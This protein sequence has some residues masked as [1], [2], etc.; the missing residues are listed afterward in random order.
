MILKLGGNVKLKYLKITS[1]M[2]ETGVSVRQVATNETTNEVIQ[3]TTYD[4]NAI[5]LPFKATKVVCGI[6]YGTI[7]GTVVDWNDDASI[8][9]AR[10]GNAA[11]TS[12]LDGVE[13]ESN[14][15]V[16]KGYTPRVGV[17]VNTGAYVGS[18]VVV[19]IYTG[20]TTLTRFWSDTASMSIREER[21]GGE[22]NQLLWRAVPE[23]APPYTIP[24]SSEA[25]SYVV[26]LD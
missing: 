10:E 4:Y 8:S 5:N 23:G 11:V 20:G 26:Y 22:E 1:D 24:G 7:N 6:L 21:T 13:S 2:F 18:L 12:G 16:F 14:G 3:D 25:T 17:N 19:N 15:A 9:F